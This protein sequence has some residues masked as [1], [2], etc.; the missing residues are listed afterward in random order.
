MTPESFCYWLQGFF[1]MHEGKVKLSSKQI[2]MIR[3][4]LDLVFEKGG[5]T[6]EPNSVPEGQPDFK[7]EDLL[8]GQRFYPRPPRYC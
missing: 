6:G 5:S 2:R 1:E 4:H 3:D 8:R 7:L